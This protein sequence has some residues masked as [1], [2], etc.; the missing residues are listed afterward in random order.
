MKVGLHLILP[1]VVAAL[2]SHSAAA[3]SCKS[4]TLQERYEHAENVGVARVIGC[5]SGVLTAQGDCPD[6]KWAFE[7]VEV[8]KG[9]PSGGTFGGLSTCDHQGRPGDLYLFFDT[10]SLCTIK[11]LEG[12]RADAAAKE[13]QI[14]REYRDGRTSDLSGHW[15]FNE[16]GGA[17]VIAHRFDPAVIQFH[18]T[19][20]N[21]QPTSDVQIEG[22]P[23]DPGQVVAVVSLA[24]SNFSGPTQLEVGEERWD[25]SR[26]TLR[27][28]TRSPAPTITI[29]QDV[30][31][32]EPAMAL[33]DKMTQPL[34]VVVTGESVWRSGSGEPTPFRAVTRTTRLGEAAAAF[35]TCVRTRKS[36]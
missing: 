22:V 15:T 33:L 16:D 34:D 28:T 26:R 31:V 24:Q 32:G 18:Y 23:I 17:C 30:I 12:Q 10:I 20:A 35:K 14:L 6:R 29:T 21:P 11:P 2:F 7:V 36:E 27:I 19:Y 8:I 3:C 1:L 4:R 9:S 13:L 5:A 25:L